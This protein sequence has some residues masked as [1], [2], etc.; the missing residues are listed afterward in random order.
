MR[1]MLPS[2]ALASEVIEGLVGEDFVSEGVH[3]ATNIDV[4]LSTPAYCT[5]VQACERK[6]MLLA[7][8]RASLLAS[9]RVMNLMKVRPSEARAWE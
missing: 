7:S 5:L 2:S 9:L 6:G 3:F 1:I 8:P 4:E